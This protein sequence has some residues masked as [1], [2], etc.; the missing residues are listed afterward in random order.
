V[1]DKLGRV[2]GEA[3]KIQLEEPFEN[4]LGASE[5]YGYKL[6]KAQQ[7]SGQKIKAETSVVRSK[8][9]NNPTMTFDRPT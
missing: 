6:D 8:S 4:S 2:G 5:E 7:I 9:T 1:N 3:N